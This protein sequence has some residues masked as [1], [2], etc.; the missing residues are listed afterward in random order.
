ML[1]AHVAMK[2]SFDLDNLESFLSEQADRHR[3]YANDRVWR[4]IQQSLHG[5]DKW[6]ALTFVSILT[7]AFLAVVL[8]FSYPNKQLIDDR[9]L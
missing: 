8:T 5:T 3:M 7:L 6:P 9:S 1:K 4:N 2:H